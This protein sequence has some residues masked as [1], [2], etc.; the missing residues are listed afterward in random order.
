MKGGSGFVDPRLMDP[1]SIDPALAATSVLAKHENPYRPD[2]GCAP[3]SAIAA[4]SVPMAGD[5]AARRFADRPPISTGCR[6]IHRAV[7][8]AI[9]DDSWRFDRDREAVARS[10]DRRARCFRAEAWSNPPRRCFQSWRTG[11]GLVRSRSRA[12]PPRGA[13]ITRRKLPTGTDRSSL[14]SE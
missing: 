6:S 1:R 8:P 2:P 5:S 4:A 11:S 9:R 12:R 7:R 13:F 10:S 3:R 14:P